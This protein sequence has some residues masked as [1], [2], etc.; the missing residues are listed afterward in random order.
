MLAVGFVLG[1][2]ATLCGMIVQGQKKHRGYYRIP[3]G[4]EV[5]ESTL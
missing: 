4:E 5:G 1:C 3:N 2:T